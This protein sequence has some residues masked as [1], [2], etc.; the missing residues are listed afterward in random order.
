[1][2]KTIVWLSS[3]IQHYGRPPHKISAAQ[4]YYFTCTF[5]CIM[6]VIKLSCDQIYFCKGTVVFLGISVLK[7]VAYIRSMLRLSDN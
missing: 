4:G 5:V 6:L 3:Q 2:S 7:P 1:M